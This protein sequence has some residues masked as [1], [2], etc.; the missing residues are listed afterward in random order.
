MSTPRSFRR[1]EFRLG[2]SS[3]TCWAG[4]SRPAT[5]KCYRCS[6]FFMS[7]R[8][9]LRFAFVF[10]LCVAMRLP[11]Q[12]PIVW[13]LDS[14]NR[15]GGHKATVSGSPRL[16]ETAQGQAVEFDGKRDGLFVDFNP[17]AGL[18]QFTAEVIFQPAASG[19]K[20]QRFVHM[21]EDGSE[22]RL[23]FE[24][25]LTDD[26]RWFLDAFIKSGTGNYTLFAEKS[27]HPIGPWYHAAIVMDG[28]TMR[29]YVNGV[30]ELSTPINF[31]PQKS[32]RAS[33]G[34]R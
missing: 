1:W 25:R 3:A 33:I 23:L 13:H 4:R 2:P 17:L 29:H 7:R 14:I 32:G 30:E 19:P 24:I 28:T 8:S 31:E 11:A 6:E 18:K 34:V 26:N 22:N 5:V 27:R 16:I 9:I 10:S 15:I 21:Q 20:E 12:E